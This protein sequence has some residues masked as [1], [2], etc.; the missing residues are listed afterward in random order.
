VSAWLDDLR[1]RLPRHAE[2]IDALVA[3]CAADERIEVLE[4]QC[5]I[6]R[7]TGD[8]LS[9]LDL[10]LAVRDPDWEAVAA[11]LPDRLREIS[12]TV[13]LLDH[14]MP[15][16]GTRAHRRIFVQ[17]TDGRQVDLVVQPTSNLAGRVP[18]AVVLYDPDRHLDT[19]RR[20][21]S[22][23]ATAD[24]VR[25]WEVLGWELLANVAKYLARG[26]TWEALERLHDARAMA[27]RLHAVAEGVTYPGFGL[28]SLLDADPPR[29]PDGLEATVSGLAPGA[30]R[31]AALAC[32]E[33]LRR[34]AAGARSR[35]EIDRPESPMAAH[36]LELLLERAGP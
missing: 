36:V 12:G 24:D 17:Y 21:A 8:E 18:G 35:L 3:I 23:S 22:I 26:S 31:A 30:L 25:A 4:L 27:L 1:G 19:E 14:T 5:S 10:G 33:L 16:W 6:A 20:P 13:D 34:A 29:L 2:L 9:D 15:E 7:G 32:C 11:D 28:T